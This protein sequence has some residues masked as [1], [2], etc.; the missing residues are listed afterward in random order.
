MKYVQVI[1]NSRTVTGDLMQFS[2]SSVQKMNKVHLKTEPCGISFSDGKSCNCANSNIKWT[3]VQKYFII[4]LGR[5]KDIVFLWD[6]EEASVY[7]FFSRTLA[8]ALRR[9][10]GL[11]F[12]GSV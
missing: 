5:G 10:V 8:M 6:E 2:I 7:K 12:A 4:G 1:E 11:Q 9:D 3:I